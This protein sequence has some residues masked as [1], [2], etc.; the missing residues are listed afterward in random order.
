MRFLSLF[1]IGVLAATS[2]AHSQD[3]T[4][5]APRAAADVSLDDELWVSR[6]VL[7]FAPRADDP[8]LF[9]Q[10]AALEE[11]WPALAERDVVVIVDTDPAGESDARS[12]IRPHGFMMVLLSKDGTVAQRK[13]SPWSAR[14]LIHALDK[15]PLR[16]EVAKER[17]AL[18]P[19]PMQ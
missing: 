13:P 2:L 7:L 17:R 11:E 3:M 18:H 15:M 19:R 8:L 4:E 16:I 10:L 5:F 9:R 1:F 6:P 12:R 14:A